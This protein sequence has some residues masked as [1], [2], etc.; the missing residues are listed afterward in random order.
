VNLK[1]KQ[2]SIIYYVELLYHPLGTSY[3]IDHDQT[4]PSPTIL[5]IMSSKLKSNT[6]RRGGNGTVNIA[7]ENRG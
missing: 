7:P 1:N 6:G 5:K 2:V 4:K 3:S